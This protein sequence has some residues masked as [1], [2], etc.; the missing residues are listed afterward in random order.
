MHL[1]DTHCHLT[2]Y[3][4]DEVAHVIQRAAQQGV[5]KLLC[6]GAGMGDD[7]PAQALAIAERFDSVWC[8]VGVHPQ[9]AAKW[10]DISALEK[11]AKHEKVVAIGE[12]GLDFFK[13]WGS[14]PDVQ[15]RVFRDSIRL[16]R[17]VGKPLIIHCRDAHEEILQIIEDCGASE[18]GGVF[19]CY[20]QSADFAKKLHELNFLVSF[21]GIVT[22]KNT[23][24]VREELKQIPLSQIML[25]TDCPYMAPEPHRGQS[26]EPWHVRLIA[27]KIADIKGVSLEEV[28]NVTSENARKLFR[29]A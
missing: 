20:S 14:P 17:L 27:E 26:S 8:S 10:P 7:P 3:K 25:E 23:S 21:T 1:A 16:A 12:V 24:A 19:H 29:W 13:D 2:S 22:F 4:Y 18:V 15:R 6:I 28:A 9:Q 5:T 11:I